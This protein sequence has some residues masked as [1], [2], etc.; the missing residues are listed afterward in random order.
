MLFRSLMMIYGQQPKKNFLR[1]VWDNLRKKGNLV[2]ALKIPGESKATMLDDINRCM[3]EVYNMYFKGEVTL[4]QIQGSFTGLG[5]NT[6]LTMASDINTIGKFI[7]GENIVNESDFTINVNDIKSKKS[8]SDHE[9]SFL[10][11]DDEEQE[12]GQ[13]ELD[14]E[15]LNF[16]D[17]ENQ[18]DEELNFPDEEEN[19]EDN[20]VRPID[21]EDNT[22]PEETEKDDNISTELK[23]EFNAKYNNMCYYKNFLYVKLINL[24]NKL[25][26]YLSAFYE[27][28]KDE[29][30]A[31]KLLINGLNDEKI[32]A[33][34]E[35]INENKSLVKQVRQNFLEFEEFINSHEEL[36]GRSEL[37]ESDEVSNIS[38]DKFESL[39]KHKVLI[40][41]INNVVLKYTPD[42]FN[43]QIKN[44]SIELYNKL[45]EYYKLCIDGFIDTNKELFLKINYKKF[46]VVNSN[47]GIIEQPLI[48]VLQADEENVQT[49][50][51][52]F[53]EAKNIIKKVN[54]E[55]GTEYSFN[56]KTP[57]DIGSFMGGLYNKFSSDIDS[58]KEKFG[59][60]LDKLVIPMSKDSNDKFIET[61][62]FL[63]EKAIE[64]INKYKT[65][66][67]SVV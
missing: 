5:V 67:K 15:E 48:N 61:I 50:E 28:T 1:R 38:L 62:N 25:R 6:A 35:F 39:L 29:T 49:T 9:R 64:R 43:V 18:D 27:K 12:E 57:S 46:G 4:E 13:E 58:V 31:K 32:D 7:F 65:D 36:K 2:R 55:D 51:D 21:P 44:N 20:E 40:P 14:D 53:K 37:F 52:V 66:R 30:K 60:T 10:N 19:E 11:L 33:Y 63:K 45:Q 47:I 16:P 3:A 23:K 56:L 59:V 24:D 26:R 17:E 22:E 34:A 42:E 8:F 41:Y 54:G